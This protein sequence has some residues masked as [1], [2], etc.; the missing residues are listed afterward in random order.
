MSKLGDL[1][2]RLG[3]KKQDFDKGIDEAQKS[4][5]GFQVSTRAMAAAAS[6]AWAAVAAAVVKFGK[7]AVKM[8]QT[9]GDRWNVT[10]AGV[11]GA[12]SAFVRQLASGEGFDNLFANM[13][14]AARVS[15]EVAAAMDEIFERRISANYQ[16]AEIDNQIADWQKKMRDLSEDDPERIEAANR[17]KDLTAER[18]EILKDIQRDEAA[19]ARRDFQNQTK[20][21]DE[22]TDFLVKE[23]NQNRELI[24]QA[25]Q[26]REER[27]KAVKEATV[28]SFRSP[29]LGESPAEAM[30]RIDAKY[31][32]S[33]KKVAD[34]TKLYDKGNDELVKTMADAEVA[35]IQLDTQMKHATDQADRL[36]GRLNKEDGGGKTVITK[37]AEESESS[38]AKLEAALERAD[39]K[40]KALMESHEDI[41]PVTV[42]VFAGIDEDI[43]A[44]DAE[45]DT[46]FADIDQHYQSLLDERDK[47]RDA[48]Q[49]LSEAVAGG[50]TDACQELMNQLTGLEEFNPGAVVKALLEPL[51]DMAV[52]AGEIIVAEGIAVE[53]A[54]KALT[55]FAG[56]GA[57][58]AGAL[59]IAA[60]SAAKA[61]LSALAKGGSS[62]AA[63]TTYS[64]AGSGSGTGT[65]DLQTELT[66]TVEGRISGGDIVLA[67]QKTLDSWNR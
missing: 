53:A 32:E 67:G 61:G 55:S 21:N 48:M 31:G 18:Y 56:L 62:G 39:R 57:I 34:W 12:Y 9:W 27:A 8:T 45:F 58:G 29:G 2:V 37:Q 63:A 3:L 5:K 23:Y 16:T 36:L 35:V 50:F 46:L 51:A 6:A 22:Q 52:K 60:G 1:F 28:R 25:R 40:R 20:L 7:D 24:N 14:E 65:Q 49:E 54:K 17:V 64:G 41:V 44:M 4:V 59:L 38:L 66:I 26:Y 19:N 47:W 33:V 30:A 13:R 11:Q 15:R 43:E 10:M 42:D